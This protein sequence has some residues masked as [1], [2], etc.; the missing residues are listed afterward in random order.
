MWACSAI[1]FRC[2]RFAPVDAKLLVDSGLAIT[3]ANAISNRH[4][5]APVAL[6][7]MRRQKKR[8]TERNEKSVKCDYRPMGT[9][10][11]IS[12]QVVARLSTDSN[13]IDLFFYVSL[14]IYSHSKCSNNIVICCFRSSFK[15][16]I[17]CTVQCPISQ[18]WRD[19]SNGRRISRRLTITINL[20]SHCSDL[21]MISF[22]DIIQTPIK[23]TLTYRQTRRQSKRRN[24]LFDRDEFTS[25]FHRNPPIEL[26]LFPSVGWFSLCSSH[27][28]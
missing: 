10:D 2:F 21:K 13:A 22:L 14:H 4:T 9:F 25:P 17:V 11:R 7:P 8:W 16:K 26:F 27:Q 24:D 12:V 20:V 6:T 5:H 18:K 1:A 23:V 15:N 3:M 28:E 19:K